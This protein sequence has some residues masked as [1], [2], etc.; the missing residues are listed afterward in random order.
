M[1]TLPDPGASE[2]LLGRTSTNVVSY[3]PRRAALAPANIEDMPREQVAATRGSL[4]MARFGETVSSMAEREL[5]RIDELR[6]REAA[7]S[8]SQKEIEMTTGETGYLKDQGGTV[9]SPGWRDKRL[10]EYDNSVS[11]L[12]DGLTA[13]QKRKFLEAAGRGRIS[14]EVGITKHAMVETDKYETNVFNAETQA[15]GNLVRSQPTNPQVLADAIGRQAMR[16]DTLLGKQGIK[17]PTLREQKQKEATGIFYA[18]AIE[19]AFDSGYSGYAQELFNKSKTFMDPKHIQELER[20]IKPAMD[21]DM[22]STVGAQGYALEKAGKTPEEVISYITEN[23]KGNVAAKNAADAQLNDL[24][25]AAAVADQN[26]Q[27]RVVAGFLEGKTDYL[28]TAEFRALSPKGQADVRTTLDNLAYTRESRAYTREQRAL[29]AEQRALTAQQRHETAV[30][31]KPETHLKYL[32]MRNAIEAGNLDSNGVMANMGDIGA[33]YGKQLLNH[34]EEIKDA[35]AKGVATFKIPE[36]M[37]DA[38][39]PGQV[40]NKEAQDR[41]AWEAAV[42]IKV[43]EYKAKNKVAPDEAAV[44]SILRGLREEVVKPSGHWFTRDTKAPEYTVVGGALPVEDAAKFI[45]KPYVG[46]KK[47]LD[48]AGA[49]AA[50]LNSLRTNFERKGLPPPTPEEALRLWNLNK[51]RMNGNISQGEIRGR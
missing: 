19:S 30:F 33:T 43:D 51:A 17:D 36:K 20:R 3:S 49:D 22:G 16:V 13:S 6:A 7:I 5:D 34:V 50:F 15:M 48:E 31:N 10:N 35:K 4:A 29:T 42:T 12:A 47:A 26:N 44:A 28:K 40:K 39:Y 25:R 1:P 24:R 8:L 18:I 41:R 9:V 38:S 45:P 32:E 21:L 46:V 27:G 37:L 23:T 14:Y 11:S 2:R